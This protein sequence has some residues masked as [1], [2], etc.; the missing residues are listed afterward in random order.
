MSVFRP[1]RRDLILAGLAGAGAG[2]AGLVL[3]VWYGR[4]K[5]RW[6]KRT[7]PRDEPFS[8]NIYVAVGEDDVVKIW[9]T[10]AEMGQG[11]M[12]TLPAILADELDADWERVEVVPALANPNYGDMMTAVSSSVRNLYDELRVAGASARA[13]LVGAAADAWGVAADACSTRHGWVVHD[14]TGR[15]ARYGALATAAGRRD[16]PTNPPLKDPAG[17]SLVGRSIDR[18][19]VPDKTTGATRFGGDV[20][21]PGMLRATV[22]HPPPGAELVAHDAEAAKSVPRVR[23]VIALST[24]V[25]V[26]ADDTWSAFRGA[27]AASAR[28][29]ELE[30]TDVEAE[31]R[32]ILDRDGAFVDESRPTIAEAFEATYFLPYLAH[33]GLEPTNATAHVTGERCEIWAP[34]QHPQG[35][36]ESAARHLGLDPARV[37]VH[38]TFLGG[39]FG[40]RVGDPEVLEAVELSRR[41]GAPVQVTWPRGEDTAQDRFRPASLHRLRAELAPDG[42]PRKW[43]HRIAAPSIAGIEAADGRVDE[44]AVQGATDLPFALE[45]V[46]VEWVPLDRSPLPPGFWRSVGHSYNAFAVECFIDELASRAGQDPA[47]YRRALYGDSPRGARARAALDRVVDMSGWPTPAPGRALGLAVHEA[48]ESVMAQVAE[49]S[50]AEGRLRVHRVWAALDCG[51]ALDP[52]NVRA[53][54]EGGVVF[55]L[56]AALWGRADPGPKGVRQRNF[57]ALRILRFSEAPEIRVELIEGGERPGGVGEIGVPPIAPAVANAVARLRGERPRRLPLEPV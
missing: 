48:F 14:P 1:T 35:V 9:L 8:P 40:R 57:D 53:Q 12:T 44:L 33:A 10:K 37:I 26:V 38:T 46:S 22:V 56:S 21:L 47:A 7:P 2:G 13:M 49:V 20:R 51:L 17:R 29:T 24:G 3:G 36:R 39:G 5:E 45:E 16:I 34:T 19:D 52:R 43:H 28:F 55:G 18:V 42:R 31:L 11:V 27:D 6:A 41:V 25:A 54:V 4:R 30:A 32:S 23:D 50:E 15:R